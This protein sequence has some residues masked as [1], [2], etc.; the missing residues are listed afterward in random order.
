MRKHFEG[1][2]G[3]ACFT[4]P[5][6]LFTARTLINLQNV[7][8]ERFGQSN[9]PELLYNL[10]KDNIFFDRL[11][12]RSKIRSSFLSVYQPCGLFIAKPCYNNICVLF[13]IA[14]IVFHTP[15]AD[16]KGTKRL[17][18][19]VFYNAGGLAV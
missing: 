10:H 19:V 14:Q 4:R 7:P 11:S 12:F 5:L 13:C 18:G 16:N 8:V 3:E 9:S 1:E 6:P 2:R 17:V 15:C